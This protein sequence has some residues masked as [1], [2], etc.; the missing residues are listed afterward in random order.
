MGR[1]RVARE[2][3]ALET[4]IMWAGHMVDVKWKKEWNKKGEWP[5]CTLSGGVHGPVVGVKCELG[6][7]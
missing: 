7:V 1:V 3:A 4:L 2:H 5:H 6:D